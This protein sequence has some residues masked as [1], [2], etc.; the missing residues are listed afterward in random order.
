M[1]A[2]HDSRNGKCR[3]PLDQHTQAMMQEPVIIKI[4][5]LLVDAKRK[6]VGGGHTSRFI[7]RGLA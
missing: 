1:R 6:A 7:N 2:G 4:R 5:L 3:G